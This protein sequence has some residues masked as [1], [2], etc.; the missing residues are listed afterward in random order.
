MQSNGH[1]TDLVKCASNRIRKAAKPSLAH[2]TRVSRIGS[3]ST[4]FCETWTAVYNVSMSN[5]WC[6]SLAL[7]GSQQIKLHELHGTWIEMREIHIK[8]CSRIIKARGKVENTKP[9]WD[10]HQNQSSTNWVRK[11]ALEWSGSWLDQMMAFVDVGETR[12]SV[13]MWRFY[14]RSRVST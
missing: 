6:Y 14:V 11:R 1:H 12:G 13:E 7:H 2:K 10:H 4:N 8:I 5:S 3:T 9:I